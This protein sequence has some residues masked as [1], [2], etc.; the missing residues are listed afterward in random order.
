MDLIIILLKKKNIILTENSS[1][2]PIQ[3]FI[4][5]FIGSSNVNFTITSNE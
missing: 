4:D 1:Q 3:I 2:H 5:N